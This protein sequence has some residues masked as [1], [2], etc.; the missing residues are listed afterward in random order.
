MN[1]GIKY[2]NVYDFSETGL[3]KNIPFFD[4]ICLIL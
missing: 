1:L 3:L 4:F 2:L